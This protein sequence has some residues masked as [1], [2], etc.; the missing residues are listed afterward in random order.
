[1][2]HPHTF[3]IYEPYDHF[4][5]FLLSLPQRFSRG[6]GE[7]IYKGRNELRVFTVNGTRLV[8]KSFGRPH[9]INQLVYGFLRPSKARRSCEHA[10]LLASLGIGSPAP[11][12]YINVRTAG[13]LLFDRSFLVTLE[14]TCPV[15]YRDLLTDRKSVV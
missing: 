15:V 10:H 9:F 14:S 12:G 7:C 13:G 5:E 8:V 3:E 6:E 4:R 11:V 1:M 2:L